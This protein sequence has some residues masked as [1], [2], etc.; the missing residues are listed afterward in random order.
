VRRLSHGVPVASFTAS[1]SSGPAPLTVTFDGSAS[2]DP[3]GQP[4]TYEWAFGDNTTSTTGPTVQHTYGAAGS[5]TATLVVRDGSGNASPPASQII[6][7]STSGNTPPTPTI[8]SPA[9]GS[10]F[11]VAQQVT[12][13][14]LPPGAALVAGPAASRASGRC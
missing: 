6:S 1:P 14:K 7:V 11:A 5:Y 2:N 4:I 13:K 8:Q 10:T 3:D 12:L 9:V